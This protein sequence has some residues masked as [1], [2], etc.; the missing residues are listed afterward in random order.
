MI[1]RKASSAPM[2][3]LSVRSTVPR[4]RAV[5]QLKPRLNGR[6]IFASCSALRN[7]IAHKAGVS[8]S[9]MNPE[10]TTAIATVNAN[11]RYIDPAMPPRNATGTNTAHSTSTMA[12]TAPETSRIASTAASNGAILRSRIR[13]STFSRTTIASSTTMPIAST[14]ANMVSVLIEKPTS[15][16]P[17]KVP[18]NDIGTTMMGIS[19]ARTVCRNR[20][21]TRMTST[22][23]SKMVIV[24]SLIDDSTNRVVSNGT[25]CCTPSGKTAFSSSMRLRTALAVASALAPDCRKTAAPIFGLPFSVLE[26]S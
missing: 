15:H 14:M 7:R 16:R 6:K 18:I 1:P 20:N 19:V 24:T 9:A 12:T 11:C 13:R 3:R 23:A 10:M 22:A 8:V 25:A 17:A 4:K 5:S 21:T 2:R 26:V